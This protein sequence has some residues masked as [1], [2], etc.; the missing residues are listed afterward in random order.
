MDTKKEVIKVDTDI[1]HILAAEDGH[2]IAG[3]ILTTGKV[4]VPVML[5]DSSYSAVQS[6]FSLLF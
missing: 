4:D 1:A 6:D 5:R 3:N 2:V